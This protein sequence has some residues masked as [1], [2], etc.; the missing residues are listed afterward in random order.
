MRSA[1]SEAVAIV[2]IV[3]VILALAFYPQFG[4]RRSEPTVK[5]TILPAQ[6]QAGYLAPQRVAL[7]MNY[8]HRRPPT[9]KPGRTSTGRRSRRCWRSSPAACVILMVGLLRPGC[10]PRAGRARR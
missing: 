10:G 4:L 7:A 3:L 6:A 8:A 1:L 9:I 2:P 5:A